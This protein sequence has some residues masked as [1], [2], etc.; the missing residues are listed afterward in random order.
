M[1]IT[2]IRVTHVN[3]PFDAPFYW[4]AGLYPGASKSIIEV[5]TDEGVV[6]LGE[7]P[8]WHFGEIIKEEIT[9]A[10]IGADPLDLADC[11]ARCVP[12]Y[13]ITANTGENAATVAFGAVELALWDIRGKVFDMP[14]YKL[15]GG[16]VRKDIPFTE[17]FAFRPEQNGAGGEMSPEA[18]TE[19]C[20]KMREEHGSTFFEGKLILGDPNLEI[21]TVKMMREALG[22]DAM[23]RLDSNMQ[24]SLTT[25]RWVLREI[26]QYNIRNYEDPVATFEEMAE[27]RKHSIIP[28]STHIP[29]LR[30]AVD[31]GAP[32]YFVCNFAALGGISNTMKFIAACEAMGKGFWCYSNDLGIMTSAYLHVVAATPWITEPS[33]SL[34]RWQIGDVIEEG[35]FR[36]ANNVI[37]VPEGAGLGVKLCAESMKRWAK[38]FEDNGPMSHFYDPKNPGRYRKLPLN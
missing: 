36:Q 14:L 5:F 2:D 13:Q 27:L 25:A 7:A 3:V 26:E 19:Y 11:E 1:K 20:L 18:I 38:D 9:P 23:I 8:W 16:A 12:P 22:E 6:G 10:L 21:K 29:D 34:F 31:L 33:Q 4:S 35:P 17:Y 37:P 15:L 30:R 24:W 32:D 28:F